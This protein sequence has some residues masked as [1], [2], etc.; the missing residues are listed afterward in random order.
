M[1]NIRITS[2]NLR[3]RGIK[4]P[5]SE[6]THPMGSREKIALFNMI[7]EKLPGAVVLDAFAGSGALGIEALS[8]RAERVVFLEKSPKVA[9]IIRENVENLNIDNIAAI[10]TTDVAKYNTEERFDIII[11]DPPYDKFDVN[12]ILP[13]VRLLKKSGVLVLS[14]PSD[15]PEISGLKLQK[16]KQY[17]NARISVFTF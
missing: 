12:S 3:G 7:S 8:R 11:A 4:S 9:K 16:S 15:A 13:L 6:L 14:H 1:E 2:G 17:A 10:I 5:K